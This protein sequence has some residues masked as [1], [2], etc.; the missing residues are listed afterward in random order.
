V[1]L[2]LFLRALAMRYVRQSAGMFSG[3]RRR[4]PQGSGGRQGGNIGVEHFEDSHSQVGGKCASTYRVKWAS[5][6][7]I[8]RR[9]VGKSRRVKS[10]YQVTESSKC[11][12]PSCAH[13]GENVNFLVRFYTQNGFRSTSKPRTQKLTF[14]FRWGGL[15]HTGAPVAGAVLDQ[16]AETSEGGRTRSARE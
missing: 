4:P 11:P 16:E 7:H 1:A 5:R 3:P 12:T 13:G 2:V 10:T 6:D 8:K 14:F 9:D 15:G